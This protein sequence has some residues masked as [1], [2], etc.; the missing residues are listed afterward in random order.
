M[1][2]IVNIWFHI[3]F[4]L[5]FISLGLS[6]VPFFLT[7][8]FVKMHIAMHVTVGRSLGKTIPWKSQ[9]GIP[10]ADLDIPMENPHDLANKYPNDH[11]DHVCVPMKKIP[12]KNIHWYPHV[13]H[14]KPLFFLF[15]K[16][17]HNPTSDRIFFSWLRQR[18]DA[19]PGSINNTSPSLAK[20]CPWITSAF[21]KSI[22]LTYRLRAVKRNQRNSSVLGKPGNLCNQLVVHV[23]VYK[24]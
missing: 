17:R 23:S 22:R 21:R 24:V 1:F 12:L 3:C 6:F 2:C 10:Q 20:S 11:D 15:K 14:E 9:E 19:T 8:Y 4:H 18:R 5:H 7:E 16:Q 13:A